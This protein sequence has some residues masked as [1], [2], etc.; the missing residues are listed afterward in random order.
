VASTRTQ[1]RTVRFSK[2]EAARVDAYLQRNPIFDSF[3]SLARVATLSFLG[4]ARQLNL[5][6]VSGDTKQRPRLFWDY[7]LSETQVRELL[8]RPGL[9]DAKR[10]VMERILSEG[11]FDE[12][13]EYLSREELARHFSKLSLPP[14]KKRHWAY[15]LERWSQSD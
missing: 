2:A 13:F 15:A 3:S 5:E 9:A 1:L 14:E 4:E 11:R 8:A 10:F 6:P 12:V 7:D